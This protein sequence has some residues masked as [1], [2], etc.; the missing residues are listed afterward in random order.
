MTWIKKLDKLIVRFVFYFLNFLQ[1]DFAT[2]LYKKIS[3]LFKDG[4]MHTGMFLRICLTLISVFI[5]LL[6]NLFLLI[7]VLIICILRCNFKY[8][9]K[10]LLKFLL[11]SLVNY[12]I[13]FKISLLLLLL[14]I[15]YKTIKKVDFVYEHSFLLSILLYTSKFFDNYLLPIVNKSIIVKLNLIRGGTL[16]PPSV[17]RGSTSNTRRNYSTS[18]SLSE[19]EFTSRFLN[20]DLETKLFTKMDEILRLKI[21]TTNKQRRL[22]KLMNV[23]LLSKSEKQ[24]ELNPF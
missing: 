20:S 16:V 21:N 1:R 15:F 23:F 24:F 9:F 6:F 4:Y 13:G 11:F 10:K 19:S 3:H 22:E 2:D 18:F 14:F 5:S 17:K 7:V 8:V 12:L